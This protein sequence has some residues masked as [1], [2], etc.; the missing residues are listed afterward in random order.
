MEDTYAHEYLKILVEC[1]VDVS[2]LDQYFLERAIN[3]G[4]SKIVRVFLS[5]PYIEPQY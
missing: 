5:S 3:T 4:E 1:D 2:I